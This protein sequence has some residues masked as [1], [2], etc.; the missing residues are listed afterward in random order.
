MTPA[1]MLVAAL[2]T[3]VLILV[4]LVVAVAMLRRVGGIRCCS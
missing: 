3:P 4:A 1:K 2:M